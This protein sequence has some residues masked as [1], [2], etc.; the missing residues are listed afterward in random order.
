MVYDG[1]VVHYSEIALKGHNRGVFERRLAENIKRVLGPG[2]RVRRL[3]GRLLVEFGGRLGVEESNHLARKVADVFGVE[4]CSPVAYS[5]LDVADIAEKARSLL[6]SGY[7]QAR[8]FK[9]ET[10]R[11]NKNFPYTSVEL[12]RLV[13]EEIKSR[14]RLEVDLLT[15]TW[16]WA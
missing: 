6:L 3:N 5:R 10:R 16:W 11:Q 1:I 14:L 13:G 15:R 7:E 12:N 9:V 4:W 8:K 2:F